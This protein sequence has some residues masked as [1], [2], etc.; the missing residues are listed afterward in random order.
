MNNLQAFQGHKE[1]IRDV[2]WAPND[3]RFATG[4]DDST[5]KLWNFEQMRE[6]RTLTGH[7]WD[8]KCVKWHPTKGLIVSGGKDNL[9]KFWDPR[10]GTCL[11]TLHDHKNTVQAAEWS[12]N[13]NLVATAS[14]DST[15]KVFDIRAMRE[16]VTLRGHKKE[17]CSLAWHPI[18]SDILVSGG[19]EGSI[20]HWTVPDATPKDNLEFAHDSNVWSLAFHP[21][22]HIL[23][24][25][26]NDHTT[27]FWSRGRPGLS[28]KGDRFHIGRDAAAANGV[29]EIEDGKQFSHSSRLARFVLLILSLATRR[30]RRLPPR[31]ALDPRSPRHGPR[32]RRRR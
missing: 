14:R 22:G 32:L 21:L 2:S 25:A 15:V 12:P 11:S 26:S 5:I 28:V 27:R 31:P 24:S 13:G 18:H 6:E 29:Q 20:L 19:S 3:T 4:S 17:V 7:G 30:P 10:T 23:C 16:L 8:V 9:V 1:S